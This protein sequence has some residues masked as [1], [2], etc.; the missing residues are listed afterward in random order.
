MCVRAVVC[1][2]V[3]VYEHMCIERNELVFPTV[4]FSI[5]HTEKHMVRTCMCMYRYV[6]VCVNK[7]DLDCGYN[8]QCLV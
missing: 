8:G 5:H 1:V 7:L 3:Y 4:A 6:V 2:C